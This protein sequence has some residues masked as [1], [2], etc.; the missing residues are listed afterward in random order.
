MVGIYKSDVNFGRR[1]FSGL[2]SDRE[3]NTEISG[4]KSIGE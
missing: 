2:P 3:I 4:I 1:Y